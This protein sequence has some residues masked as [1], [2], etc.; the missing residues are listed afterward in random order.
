MNIFRLHIRPKSGEANPRK[1]FDYCLRNSI[2]GMGW[3][4]GEATSITWDD[5]LVKATAKYG[6]NALSLLSRVK[7]FRNKV[8]VDDLLWTRDADGKYYLAKVVKPWR[9]Y[10]NHESIEADIANICDC[11]IK[12]IPHADEVPGKIVACFRP[13]KTIQRIANDSCVRFSQH[14]WN[15]LSASEDYIITQDGQVKLYS[16]LS[17]EDCEDALADRKSVV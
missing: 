4:V 15:Q 14:L 9:Y 10:A 16:L 13:R 11:A 1:S 6:P 2:L 8:Q 3:V 12:A 5:Y 17:S 7:Y